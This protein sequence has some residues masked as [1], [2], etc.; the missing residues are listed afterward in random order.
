VGAMPAFLN[1]YQ[2]KLAVRPEANDLQV[3]KV[4]EYVRQHSRPEDKVLTWGTGGAINFLTGRQV[5]HKFFYVHAILS[6]NWPKI[7]LGRFADDIRHH[8]P[9]LILDCSSRSDIANTLGKGQ[10]QIAGTAKNTFGGFYE[11]DVSPMAK[12]VEDLYEPEAV[13]EDAVIYRLK[14]RVG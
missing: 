9:E 13:V 10:Y 3:V 6:K 12:V 14:R 5:P 4:A 8:P 2:I 1:L 7:S 11:T